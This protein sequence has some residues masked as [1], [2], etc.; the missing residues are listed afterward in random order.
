[1]RSRPGLVVPI[2]DRRKKRRILTLKNFGQA[3]LAFAI[4]FLG[5]L[6]LTLVSDLRHPKSGD[7]GRLFGKQV[8][9]QT[10]VTPQKP[11]IIREAPISDD[12]AADP[13]LLSAAAREQY[14]GVNGPLQPVVATAAGEPAPHADG[15]SVN[16][17]NGV[18][19]VRRGTQQPQ[20]TLS[21][22]IFR[23]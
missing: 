5:L 1:M 2:R 17:P 6:G 7:Y 12:T 21:G 10:E 9:S 3:I 13:M 19:I 8:S 20:A 11:E 14:L 23:Q 15:S 22:G 16:G 4:L 18:T